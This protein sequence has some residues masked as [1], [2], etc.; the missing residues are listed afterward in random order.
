MGLERVRAVLVGPVRDR[1][2][3]RWCLVGFSEL[4]LRGQDNRGH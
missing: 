1:G 4:F 3:S 2:R